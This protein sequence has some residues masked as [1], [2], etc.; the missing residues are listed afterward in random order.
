M[1]PEGG[2]AAIVL[3]AGLSSRMGQFKPL[4]PMGGMSFLERLTDS[5]RQAGVES[6]LVV[7]GHRQAALM[8]LIKELRLDYVYNARYRE[9][10]LI[11]VKCG[12]QA[13][14]DDCRAFFIAPVDVPGVN[15][16]T[17]SR[18]L[19]A[20]SEGRGGIIY[21]LCNGRR[22]HPPLIGGALK[23][24]L[25]EWQGSGGLKSFLREHESLALDLPVDD[26]GVLVDY[27]TPADLASLPQRSH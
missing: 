15:Y 7:T 16:V 24:E 22:G 23:E 10:M 26:P 6:I 27:D 5:F 2:I 18:Q 12:V 9:E 4:L 11:S 21:P 20:Y 17:L 14:K 19:S 3:A 1:N 8:P 13:L 25:L